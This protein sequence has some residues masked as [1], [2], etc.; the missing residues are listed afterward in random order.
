[1]AIAP[2]EHAIFHAGNVG[3]G[4]PG[5]EEEMLALLDRASRSPSWPVRENTAR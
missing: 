5:F 4:I 1:M 3:S 2:E